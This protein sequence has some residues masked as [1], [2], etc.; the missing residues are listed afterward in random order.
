LPLSIDTIEIKDFRNYREFS[1]SPGAEISIVVGPNAV[2][3]TNLV[4][5][6]QLVT[7]G[8]SFRRPKWNE[9]VR[10]QAPSAHIHMKASGGGDFLDVSLAVVNQ[11]RSYTINDKKKRPIDLLGRMPCVVFTPDDLFMVKGPAEERRRTVDETG[12]QLS[13]GYARLRTTY[14]RLL[15]QRNAALRAGVDEHQLEILTDQIIDEGAR[16]T[17][18]RARLVERMA[19]KA[20]SIYAGLAQGESLMVTLAPSWSKYGYSASA[21]TEESSRTALAEAF[22]ASGKEEGAR[23]TTTVGPHRDDLVFM[24]DGREARAYGSQGQQRSVALAWKLAEVGVIEDVLKKRPVLL[25]DD[26]MSELDKPRR[27]SLTEL[28]SLTTQTVITTTNIQYFDPD[29]LARATVLELDR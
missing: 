21:Q 20:A 29:M 3:K 25:L 23:Q 8:E 5:A 10:S 22:R 19:A 13:A 14:T 24:I 27:E 12:D 15:R 7:A 1:F 11:R 6:I 18:H 28:L 4:E 2:G 26:V 16:L 17:T 9:I